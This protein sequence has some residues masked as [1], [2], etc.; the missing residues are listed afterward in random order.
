MKMK[1]QIT[2]PFLRLITA[3]HNETHEIGSLN[4][5]TSEIENSNDVLD[6][7]RFTGIMDMIYGVVNTVYSRKVLSTMIE[8]YGC[9]CFVD[10][11]RMAGGK[12]QPVDDQD[13]LCR[14][15]AQCHTCVGID[16]TQKCDPDIGN[17]RY[18]IDGTLKTISCDDQK[19]K[20]PCKRNACECDRLFALE[21]SKMWD[22]GS[23]N[24]FYW[25]NKH[26]IKAGNPTFKKEQR[27]QVTNFGNPKDECCGKYPERRPYNSVL[28]ECCSD[29]KVRATGSC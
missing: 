15:L 12:G 29:G 21:F 24:K 14:K 25:K 1:F 9:H 11:S 10:G 28:Y 26:N 7:R 17:Y 6:A 22:D 16:H 8:N 2:L 27:C 19:N 5:I 20:S 13:A 3:T 4:S 18:T 23:F